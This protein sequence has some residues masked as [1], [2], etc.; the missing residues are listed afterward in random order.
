MIYSIGHGNKNFEYFLN[1]LN[2]FKIQYLID[3]RTNPYSKYNSQYNREILKSNLQHADIIY[4]YM[5]ANLGGLPADPSCYNADGKVNYNI[6]KEKEF[7][8]AG[9]QRLINAY[10][11]HLAVV[12]MCSETK[13]EECHRSKLIGEELLK[14]NIQVQ[15]IIEVNK[16]KDQSIVITG[17]LDLFTTDL[18]LTSRKK[19]S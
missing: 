14:N 17:N 8:Q 4:V 18:V 11:K 12:L 19:Y 2:S 9:L 7:F 3:I 15:H 16:T 1:E 13:P 10:K 5:G 6:I